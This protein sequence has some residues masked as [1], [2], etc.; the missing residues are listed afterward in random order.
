[1]TKF[2]LTASFCCILSISAATAAQEEPNRGRSALFDMNRSIIDLKAAEPQN[3]ARFREQPSAT[4]LPTPEASSAPTPSKSQD[5]VPSTTP[6][7]EPAQTTPP[8][9]QPPPQVSREVVISVPDQRLVI[10]QNGEQVA[11]FPVSTSKF[12]LG[13]RHGSYRTPLG[14]HQITDKIGGAAP[15]GAVFRGR[16]RTGEVLKPNAP[17]RDPIV[18]RII[19]LRGLEA[20]NANA[21]ARGIYIHGT[22]EETKI[23]KK[24]SYGCIRMKSSDVV[25]VFEIVEEGD[26]VSIVNAPAR[27]AVKELRQASLKKAQPAPAS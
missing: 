14:K 7:S 15:L 17:G 8:Q 25:R 5:S 11:S 18:T 1:M 23:G 22:T 12:G 19:W 21:H 20:G 10:V 9:P 13:D 2:L 4:S 3:P 16:N 26:M 27:R 24:A 6:A